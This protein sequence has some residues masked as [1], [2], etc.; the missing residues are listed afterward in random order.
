MYDELYLFRKAT[1]GCFRL[2]VRFFR[3][4]L[5][6]IVLF[7]V[8]LIVFGTVSYLLKD[9]IETPSKTMPIQKKETSK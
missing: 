3:V 6:L 8:G 7:G 9:D 5:T 2:A 4:I 1:P